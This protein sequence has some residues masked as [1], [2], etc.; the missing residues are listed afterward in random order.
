MTIKELEEQVAVLTTRMD[1]MSTNI[2]E[3]LRD[4][5]TYHTILQN[6]QALLQ[7]RPANQV[8]P[9]RPQP[10][11][12]HHHDEEVGPIFQRKTLR[13]DFPRFDGIDPE[14]WLFQAEQYQE[15]NGV[16]DAQ[17][18]P[19]A[20]VHLQGDAIP[21]YHW[22]KQSIGLLTWQQFSRAICAR[23]GSRQHIDPCSS[24]SKLSQTD[25]VR[26]FITEFE[27]L[28]NLVPGM[29]ESHQVSIFLSGLRANIRA[30][31]RLLRPVGLIE[32]FELALCQEDAITATTIHNATRI[33]DFQILKFK[34]VGKN[35]IPIY[36]LSICMESEIAR[37]GNP[38][39]AF[40]TS[41]TACKL[42]DP[43]RRAA[44]PVD[45]DW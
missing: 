11:R 7:D 45:S 29:L 36:I 24:L 22:L 13:I 1:E 31:V 2:Q 5:Q 39:I 17:M 38:K 41:A 25:T 21:W 35:Q 40:A 27:K 20:S 28:V 37:L 15:L 23:F 33:Y 4:R 19:L 10:N 43:L 14:G 3:L 18:V 32:A 16:T 9:E 34:F 12:D 8:N 30:G 6:I 42:P 44:V 26:E